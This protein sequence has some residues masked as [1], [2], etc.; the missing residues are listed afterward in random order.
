MA[1][2][3]SVFGRQQADGLEQLKMP[4]WDVRIRI[5]HPVNRSA[6]VTGHVVELDTR[7]A[8][9]VGQPLNQRGMVARIV[10]VPNY[11]A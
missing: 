5:R 8:D 2:V 6:G 4:R 11:Q 9:R 7:V 1:V 10:K 3:P